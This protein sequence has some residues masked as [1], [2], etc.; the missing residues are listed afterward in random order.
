MV[1]NPAFYRCR[2]GLYAFLKL[3]HNIQ[4][5]VENTVHVTASSVPADTAAMG[6][7]VGEEECESYAVEQKQDAA[8]A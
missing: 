4:E 2:K 1:S 3:P 6:E 8:I 7:A 5:A